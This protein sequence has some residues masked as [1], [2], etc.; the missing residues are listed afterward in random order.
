MKLLNA[1]IFMILALGT[2]L[3]RAESTLYQCEF[4]QDP[5]DIKRI[6][7]YRGTLHKFV[8]TA[9]IE[10]SSIPRF[11]LYNNDSYVAG[12]IKFAKNAFHTEGD[13]SPLNGKVISFG[14]LR[15]DIVSD[16]Q[17]VSKIV[18]KISFSVDHKKHSHS[19]IELIPAA[20]DESEIAKLFN[21]DRISINFM[22]RGFRIRGL[23]RE[24]LTETSKRHIEYP[25]WGAFSFST[26]TAGNGN[27][28]DCRIVKDLEKDKD[29]S[30]LSK[31]LSNKK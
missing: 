16:I 11:T 22:I 3:A 9:Y 20:S 12:F 8:E 28:L 2:T 14:R 13:W 26:P 30:K 4:V 15:S 7:N 31:E 18:S 27:E 17:L 21:K 5:E 6:E 10:V 1:V 23:L 24:S 19:F 25:L 29:I